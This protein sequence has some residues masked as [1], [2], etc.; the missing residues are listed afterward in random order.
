M[1]LGGAISAQAPTKAVI[2]NRV[3]A[4]AVVARA[5]KH[6]VNPIVRIRVHTRS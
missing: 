4:R 6:L 2:T 3:V 1:I 5:E